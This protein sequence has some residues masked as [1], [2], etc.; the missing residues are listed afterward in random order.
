MP[1]V[2]GSGYVTSSLG[3]P[4]VCFARFSRFD[5]DNEDDDDDMD[6][7]SSTNTSINSRNGTR[8]RRRSPR[9]LGNVD[10]ES[11]P[12]LQ[13]TIET[14]VNNND[15]ASDE[16]LSVSLSSSVQAPPASSQSTQRSRK[17]GTDHDGGSLG[18]V[19]SHDGIQP[20]SDRSMAR[21]RGRY[22]VKQPPPR[23]D[24]DLLSEGIFGADCLYRT[25]SINEIDRLVG[26]ATHIDRSG[27]AV[28]D[29][30][31]ESHAQ[32]T[33][34]VE[35]CC[36]EQHS[37]LSLPNDPPRPSL[38]HGLKRY[39]DDTKPKMSSISDAMVA[40]D[41]DED[42]AENQVD[43]AE[44][45]ESTTS[46]ETMTN[47]MALSLLWDSMDTSAKVAIGT[48]VED[49]IT[50]SLLPMARKHVERCRQLTAIHEGA[51]TKSRQGIDRKPQQRQ[52]AFVE[53]TLPAAEAI[54][55]SSN[56]K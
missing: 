45:H 39:F 5:N 53:W 35:T 32:S 41:K 10:D 8:T 38:L 46:S 4:F 6:N 19:T 29:N 13:R 50:N 3:T 51:T 44:D 23:I 36:T 18:S 30:T 7:E 52:Q 14:N 22:S 40:D 47:A 25:L 12:T 55:R 1:F 48:L 49:T 43:S 2:K 21:K 31:D 11:L 54:F 42:E 28:G 33:S 27:S 9:R 16:S 17:R 56:K 24:F 20:W 34:M 26:W 37:L 15:E